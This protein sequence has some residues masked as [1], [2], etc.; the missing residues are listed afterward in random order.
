M[1]KDSR[2]GFLKIGRQDQHSSAIS[3]SNA[4]TIVVRGRDLTRE[5]IG[6][7]ELHRAHLAAAHRRAALGR[8][9]RVL[10]A[11]LV[12]IAEHGLV[13]SVQAARMTLA[14]APEALQGAV[15]AGILGCGSVVLG[16]SEAGGR[17]LREMRGAGRR[18]AQPRGGDHGG[19]RRVPC[20]PPRHPGLRPS[21]AQGRAI[22]ARSGCSR[23]RAEA[24]VAGRH[25]EIAR[26][27]R[28]AAAGTDRPAAGA[29]CL[30]RHS[31]GAA[32]CRLPAAGPQGRADPGA[33]RRP[34][35]APARGAA[36]PDRLRDVARGRAGHRLRRGVPAGLHARAR[37]PEA[38]ARHALRHPRRRAGHL[39]HRPVRRHDAGGPGR[40][41]DQGREPG[42]R[43]VPRLPGRPVLA[44][45]PGLQP[46]Q[47]QPRARH[48]AGARLRALR[49]P[50]PRGG[51]L[52]PELPA[53]HRRAPRRRCRALHA[54]SI[55]AWC[56]ARSAASAPAVRTSTGRATTRWRRR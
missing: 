30:R 33:H 5:L 36:A 28:A 8:Q 9:R 53:R 46:Q 41:C 52:H 42:R 19:R 49:R 12:A 6:T 51:R 44:A 47:A 32:G 56:T 29:Q 31:G 54:S 43:S 25:I 23:S 22:R 16:A 45:L 1:R 50:D 26:A 11:T 35:R 39:H 48:E 20:R 40:G 27:R 17:F 38:H 55:R 37:T 18:A 7:I 2:G 3:T 15:A 14:A 13:P 34:D 24:G 21:A 4:E 10:D